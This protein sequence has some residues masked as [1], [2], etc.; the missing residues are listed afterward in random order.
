VHCPNP[1][2]MTGMADPG[3]RVLVSR[4]DDSRRKLPW[5]WELVQSG[6]S[7]VAVNTALANPVVRHWLERGDLWP[8]V[9]F[10]RAEVKH[11][12]V[13]FDFGLADGGLLEVK[14]VTLMGP[15][16]L[17]AF[18]DSKTE[19]GRR[20]IDTLADLQGIRR[21]LLFFVARGDARAVRPA[22]EID[23]AYG[24]A[25]R[26]AVARGVEVHAV[27]AHFSPHGVRRGPFLDVIL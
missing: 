22:D 16:G 24:A 17:A 2:A 20:H 13:R 25:L 9:K 11:G 10:E 14:T 4:R 18:P 5:T 15:R 8:D 23:P 7:W 1:G 3:A 26:R 21:V 27:R 12:D 6:R 19:R